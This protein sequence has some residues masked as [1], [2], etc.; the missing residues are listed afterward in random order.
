MFLGALVDVGILTITASNGNDV[1]GFKLPF[2]IL[3]K[4]YNSSPSISVYFK[5]LMFIHI[6]SKVSL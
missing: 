3:D 2:K 6:C 1:A 5:H 4:K